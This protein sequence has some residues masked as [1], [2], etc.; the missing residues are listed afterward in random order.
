M[1]GPF[2]QVS[3]SRFKKNYEL[4]KSNEPLEFPDYNKYPYHVR[5]VFEYYKALVKKEDLQLFAKG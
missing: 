3:N 1:S 5:E 4:I 2:E